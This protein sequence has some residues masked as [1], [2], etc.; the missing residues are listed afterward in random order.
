MKRKA[1]I[2]ASNDNHN[3]ILNSVLCSNKYKI[4]NIFNERIY[5]ELLKDVNTIFIDSS[6]DSEIIKKVELFCLE[7]NIDLYIYPESISLRKKNI[8]T[9]EDVLF[10]NLKPYY[11]SRLNRFIKRCFDFLFALCFIIISFPLFFLI[12]LLIKLFDKGPIFYLQERITLN[13]KKFVIFKFRTM[14][15][16]A[17]KETGVTLSKQDDPRLT[18]LGRFLRKY[19]LDELP[20]IFNVLIGNMSLVG[21]RPER[22]YFVEQYKKENGY[23]K[24]R[25]NAKAGITG[26]AQIFA[27]YDSS[28]QTKL[29]YDLYYIS[30]YSFFNDLKIIFKTIIFLFSPNKQQYRGRIELLNENNTD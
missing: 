17:E 4:V 10:F 27:K 8:Q 25:F 28:F 15:V 26:L 29:D 22:P 2:I 12:I 14:H 13:E 5:F 9:L 20:Q 18:K 23:Y 16:N 3:K 19:R 24:Y 11:I 30:N 21:P 7:N 1:S 6:V